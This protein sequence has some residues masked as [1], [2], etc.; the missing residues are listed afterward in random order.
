MAARALRAVALVLVL[1]LGEGRTCFAIETPQ[2][3]RPASRPSPSPSA[4]PTP[5]NGMVLPQGSEITL[6]LTNEVTSAGVHDGSTVPM[7]LKNAIVVNGVTVADAGTQTTLR[8]IKVNHAAVGQVDASMQIALDPLPLKT[9]GALPIRLSRELLAINHSAGEESTQELADAATMVFFPP[10]LLRHMIQKGKDVSLPAGTPIRAYTMAAV[11][12]RDRSAVIVATPKP[13]I[14]NADAVHSEYLPRP[15]SR[16]LPRPRG[17]PARQA[18]AQAPK[19]R[20]SRAERLDPS[21]V[22]RLVPLLRPRRRDP[23]PPRAHLR[24]ANPPPNSP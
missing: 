16:R 13:L 15:L 4:S 5:F 21:R 1:A 23:R 24:R 11:D 9:G 3:P 7:H 20:L 8:V 22:K 12:G 19:G 14:M 17:L 18:P 6:V 10:L 2:T